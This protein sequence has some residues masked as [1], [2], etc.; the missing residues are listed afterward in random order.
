MRGLRMN[1]LAGSDFKSAWFAAAGSA[2]LVDTKI[3]TLT[4]FSTRGATQTRALEKKYPSN[5]I[6]ITPAG[7]P[8]LFLSPLPLFEITMM[9]K[10]V[11]PCHLLACTAPVFA[12]PASDCLYL[13]FL[14]RRLGLVQRSKA[15]C[16]LARFFY[17]PKLVAL[18]DGVS[19]LNR[20]RMEGKKKPMWLGLDNNLVRRRQ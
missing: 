14:R 12:K 13:R 15:L 17:D 16:R 2:V 10:N 19:L 1:T 6:R 9:L 4:P 5:L 11:F 8:R 20:L 3:T 18:E 7:L